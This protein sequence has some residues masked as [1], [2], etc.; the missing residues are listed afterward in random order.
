MKLLIACVCL[1]ASACAMNAAAP[2]SNQKISIDNRNYVISQLTAGT[3]TASTSG[4]ATAMTSD[5]RAALLAAIEKASGCK[6]TDSD[7]SRQSHQLDAQVDCGSRM[8]N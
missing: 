1:I 3:W 5:T 2:N 6:V 4:T 7:L 8:K